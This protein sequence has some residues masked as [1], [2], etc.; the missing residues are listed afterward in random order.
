MSKLFS[1]ESFLEKSRFPLSYFHCT[2]LAYVQTSL[3]VS[4]NYIANLSGCNHFI[5]YL[6]FTYRF[7]V[8]WTGSQS[9]SFTS[10]AVI[11]CNVMLMT[12]FAT[13][14]GTFDCSR[15]SPQKSLL[16]RKYNHSL[17]NYYSFIEERTM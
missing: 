14:P 13:S 8:A 6:Y 10:F 12:L 2:S 7:Y 9:P 5:A 3:G 11:I 16:L 4:P 17:K 15:F 1:K